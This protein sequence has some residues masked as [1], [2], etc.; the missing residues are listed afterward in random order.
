MS[1][2]IPSLQQWNQNDPAMVQALGQT[3]A[4]EIA[5]AFGGAS[6][7]PSNSATPYPD[8]PA[9]GHADSRWI[10]PPLPRR[11]DYLLS[12]PQ[13]QHRTPAPSRSPSRAHQQDPWRSAS[14]SNHRQRSISF[15]ATPRQSLWAEVQPRYRRPRIGVSAANHSYS[16]PLPRVR[17]GFGPVETPHVGGIHGQEHNSV[18]GITKP[19]KEWIKEED[20]TMVE[21]MSSGYSW[22][23]IAPRF[24]DRTALSVRQRF[25]RHRRGSPQA[26]GH[27]RSMHARLERPPREQTKQFKPHEMSMIQELKGRGHSWEEIASHLPGRTAW[28]VRRRYQNCKA[29][30]KW[31]KAGED[32]SAPRM[33]H[34]HGDHDEAEL[35][36]PS[37]A[38]QP[39]EPS[40][41][42]DFL[43]APGFVKATGQCQPLLSDQPTEADQP[44]EFDLVFDPDQTQGQLQP[45]V[46]HFPSTRPSDFRKRWLDNKCSWSDAETA[47]LIDLIDNQGLGFSA[48]SQSFPDRS[49]Y[50]VK[51]K[52]YRLS[53][54]DRM[55]LNPKVHRPGAA[56]GVE[57]IDS[58]LGGNGRVISTHMPAI[59]RQ[60]SEHHP[61]T[62]MGGHQGQ[63]MQFAAGDHEGEMSASESAEAPGSRPR[64]RGPSRQ[65]EPCHIP[66]GIW[67]Y[68]IDPR[69]KSDVAGIDGEPSTP[70]TLVNAAQPSPPHPH[71]RLAVDDAGSSSPA[72]LDQWHQHAS[73]K[74]VVLI[75]ATVDPTTSG[76][77]QPGLRPDH[78]S[79]PEAPQ[80]MVPG[81]RKH[82]DHTSSSIVRGPGSEAHT[83][84]ASGRPTK[85]RR[86]TSNEPRMTPMQNIGTVAPRSR[87]AT[88]SSV[89]VRQFLGRPAA[90][91]DQDSED[92][93]A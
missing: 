55:Q 64:R 73:R 14:V 35:L 91:Q 19:R 87:G 68:A 6:V 60:S 10:A 62:V 20:V 84:F 56:N 83:R 28:S 54:E 69:S 57:C 46:T 39:S 21:L 89:A 27:E 81:K 45:T 66:E 80:A 38:Q 48:A 41:A 79:T 17:G 72:A 74:P 53:E 61:D 85:Y 3:I 65:N 75:D 13:E 42:L 44:P 82:A 47:L 30:A 50:S 78:T 29:K 12:E 76:R 8:T 26:V 67:D 70:A 36:Q 88:P 2:V 49:V 7:A 52:H 86:S 71:P 32:T 63:E 4:K 93:L 31:S 22:E 92:E 59:S 24:A 90:A 43:Q 5:K 51:G 9:Q 58:R 23:E 77:E 34:E 16:S 25:Y 18:P 15:G 37:Q 33:E 11:P 40:R 1:S